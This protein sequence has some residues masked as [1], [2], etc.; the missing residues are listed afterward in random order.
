MQ[1]LSQDR[2][3]SVV[4]LG[5]QTELIVRRVHSSEDNNEL[6]IAIIGRV[7]QMRK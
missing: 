3:V 2:R 6:C 7:P 5:V 4:L 1:D